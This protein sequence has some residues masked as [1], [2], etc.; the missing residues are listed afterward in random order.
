MDEFKVWVGCLACY[1]AGRLNGQWMDA[2]EAPEWKCDRAHHEE[3]WCFDIEAPHA[4]LRHEM[5]PM[6]AAA[7]AEALAEVQ[8]N[9]H[10]P[11]AYLAWCANVGADVK[12]YADN[13]SSFEDGFCGTWDS[14]RD[15]AD[16]WAEQ[17]IAS[18]FPDGNEFVER[19]FDWDK[20]CDEMFE[21]GPFWTE[22]A[23]GGGVYIFNGD[24]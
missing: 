20:H 19:Y 10:P 2:E 1:N 12:E 18:H 5:S 4:S 13:Q 14:P 8:A 15:Y 11:V 9:F 22:D 7:I 24:A 16:D 23:D 17:M 6:E 3:F 21:H